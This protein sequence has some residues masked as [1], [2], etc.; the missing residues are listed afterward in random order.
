MEDHPEVSG[1]SLERIDHVCLSEFERDD[2][3]L[4]PDFQEAAVEG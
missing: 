1:G 2:G 3:L 4:L